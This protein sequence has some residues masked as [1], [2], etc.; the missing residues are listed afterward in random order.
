MSGRPQTAPTWRVL[1]V[2]PDTI[3]SGQSAIG[4]VALTGPAPASGVTV[5]IFSS[6]PS[7]ITA[8]SS[9]QVPGGLTTV[10]FNVTAAA[11]PVQTTA[12][13]TASYRGVV[14]DVE[15]T[16]NPLMASFSLSSPAVAGASSVTGTIVFTGP[17]PSGTSL[18][19]TSSDPSVT[20]TSPLNVTA[21]ATSATFTA[22]TSVVTSPILVTI[23]V[24]NGAQTLYAYL[25]EDPP[26]TL[27]NLAITPTIVTGGLYSVG[28]VTLTAAAPIGGILIPIL[29]S[30]PSVATA[31]PLVTVPYGKRSVSF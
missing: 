1:A 23:S 26:A 29:S 11:V 15:V 16:I 17:A 31:E 14:Q 20:V 8:P 4:E 28:V 24:S 21:G 6:N 25:L 2:S 27:K 18:T 7:L 3:L 9:V 19:L 30:T 13:L 12:T 10:F 22:T 5:Q